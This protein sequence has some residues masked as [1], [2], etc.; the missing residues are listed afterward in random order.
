MTKQRRAK[1]SG[2]VFK[3][4]NSWVAK[5]SNKWCRAKTR[6]E[7]NARLKQLIKDHARGLRY[8]KENT[9]LREYIND[10]NEVF[11]KPNTPKKATLLYKEDLLKY[12]YNDKVL[13]S[14]RVIDLTETDIQRF[15]NSFKL[16]NGNV[17]SKETK[18]KVKGMLNRILKK[19][20]KENLLAFNI[21]EDIKLIGTKPIEKKT[22]TQKELNALLTVAKSHR[23]Y[24]L[25][26]IVAT[27]GLRIGEALA[28][29]WNDIDFNTKELNINKSYSKVGTKFEIGDTKTPNS[30][31]I[32][33]IPPQTL[34]VLHKAYILRGKDT[35][36]ISPVCYLKSNTKRLPIEADNFRRLLHSWCKEANITVITT[37]ELR[38]T[39][40]TLAYHNGMTLKDIAHYLGHNNIKML[41][42]TYNHADKDTTKIA[43]TMDSLLKIA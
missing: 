6:E 12:L 5:L 13:I 42:K 19:A 2:S 9:T 23:L 7:A 40:A 38:H 28:L 24:P 15:F 30:K 10:Y 22:L 32:L 37:H 27:M 11:I 43:D 35:P 21:V 33:A 18:K 8:N 41:I 36:Y 1:G 31:R 16:F 39:F 26:S 14:K 20:I 25:L 29:T 4:G 34:E 3:K 17:P